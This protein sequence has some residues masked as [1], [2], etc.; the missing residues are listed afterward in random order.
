MF[1]K[2]IKDEDK[3]EKRFKIIN[4]TYSL[5]YLPLAFLGVTAIFLTV[6]G[7]FQSK[8]NRFSLYQLL[9]EFSRHVPSIVDAGAA[10]YFSRL[11]L[12]RIIKKYSDVLSTFI[13]IAAVTGVELIQARTNNAPIDYQDILYGGIGTIFHLLF[14]L[15][16]KYRPRQV[17][18]PRNLVQKIKL[19]LLR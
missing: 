14:C 19:F 16:E 8:I 15:A 7:K 2:V 11:V 10:G 17:S 1:S 9:G 18:E 12:N 4:R 5:L 13:S 6:V 3:T